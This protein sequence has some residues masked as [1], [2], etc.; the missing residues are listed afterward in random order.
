MSAL[1][2]NPWG[3][4]YATKEIDQMKFVHRVYLEAMGIETVDLP[5]ILQMNATFTS[6]LHVPTK[7]DFDEH[8]FVRQMQGVVGLLRQPAEEIIGCICG[9][10]KDRAERFQFGSAFMNDPRTLL[11]EEMKDWAMHRLA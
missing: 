2:W 5:P 1:R 11:L 8:T 7:A 10:Q 3:V 9:Y 4:N 6:P